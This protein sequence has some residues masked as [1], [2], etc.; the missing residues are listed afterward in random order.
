MSAEGRRGLRAAA[1][2]FED[3]IA[4]EQRHLAAGNVVGER[5]PAFL[6]G[7]GTAHDDLAR[8]RA[9]LGD[10]DGARTAY[11]AGAVYYLSSVHESRKR[12][13]LLGPRQ[14]RDQPH[15]GIRAIERAL[16][17]RDDDLVACAA[18]EVVGMDEA[19]LVASDN[20]SFYAAKALAAVVLDDDRVEQFVE[21][22]RHAT[23]HDRTTGDEA[24]LLVVE[25]V[26]ERDASKVARGLEKALDRPGPYAAGTDG[27]ADREVDDHLAALCLLAGRKGLDL[28]VEAPAVPAVLVPDPSSATRVVRAGEPPGEGALPDV[29]R[30]PETGAYVVVERIPFPDGPLT[31]DDLPGTP[32][33][34]LLSDE[35]L[36]AAI[37]RLRGVDDPDRR[38]LAGELA[39]AREEGTLR[40][41][42]VVHPGERERSGYRV[43]RSVFE[44]G[45]DAVELYTG[46]DD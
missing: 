30:D 9:L 16:L 39:D 33:G 41:R 25:G 7:L 31:A 37:D 21:E 18:R 1:E 5:L 6:Y 38:E 23:R 26:A 14:R 36:D 10:G 17:S 24:A 12:R 4:G 27:E 11:A 46:E 19:V 2:R 15:T 32:D 28:S 20:R 34:R 3:R 29:H 43:E 8:T 42:L 40:R 44:A 45:I 35:W 13:G 22:Y